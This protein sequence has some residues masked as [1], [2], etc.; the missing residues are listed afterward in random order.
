M[1][2]LTIIVTDP[3][4]YNHYSKPAPLI[5]ESLKFIDQFVAEFCSNPSFATEHGYKYFPKKM[6][7]E[8]II[9]IVIEES[10]ST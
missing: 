7:Q 10:L 4:G 3:W 8:S 5:E 9:E 6:I 1:K 2:T